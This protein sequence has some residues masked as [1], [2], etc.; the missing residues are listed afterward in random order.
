[1]C[2]LTHCFISVL[3]TANHSSVQP[4]ELIQIA[5]TLLKDPKLAIL[6]L[7]EISANHKHLAEQFTTQHPSDPEI[8]ENLVGVD[9]ESETVPPE[10]ASQGLNGLPLEMNCLQRNNSIELVNGTISADNCSA[11]ASAARIWNLPN[12]MGFV[13]SAL[14]TIG[15]II[16]L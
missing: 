13:I 6:M 8:G 5:D 1:M 10:T 3:T 4:N 16:V 12:S 14:T 15:K 9:A 2:P 7:R 11:W